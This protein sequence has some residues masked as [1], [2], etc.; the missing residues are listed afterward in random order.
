[1]GLGPGSTLRHEMEVAGKNRLVTVGLVNQLGASGAVGSSHAYNGDAAVAS[2]VRDSAGVYTLTLRDKWV[3]LRGWRIGHLVAGATPANKGT[4]WKLDSEDV[5]GAKTVVFRCEIPAT[6]GAAA[7]PQ[8]PPDSSKLY[9]TL[10]LDRGL[11]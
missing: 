1:M 11:L 8:D 10:L 5:V 2:L 7:T 4:A 6:A 3:A 9:V